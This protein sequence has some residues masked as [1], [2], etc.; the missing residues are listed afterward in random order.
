MSKRDFNKASGKDAAAGRQEKLPLEIA[1]EEAERAAR[2]RQQNQAASAEQRESRSEAAGQANNKT[3]GPTAP[4]SE[5]G[6]ETAGR[7]QTASSPARETAAGISAG[8]A[9]SSRKQDAE[10]KNLSSLPNYETAP[11][12]K[13]AEAPRPQEAAERARTS[14]APAAAAEPAEPAPA[15]PEPQDTNNNYSVSG[16]PP[17]FL[18]STPPQQSKATFLP[19]PVFRE[20]DQTEPINSSNNEHIA[21][22]ARA[23]RASSKAFSRA[24]RATRTGRAARSAGLDM[25]EEY[26]SRGKFRQSLNIVRR[27]HPYIMD[28]P[29]SIT[30]ED[31]MELVRKLRAVPLYQLQDAAVE[32]NAEE[33]KRLFH[34][35]L[36]IDDHQTYRALQ[37]LA[38]QRAS[39]SLYTIGWS[40]LQRYFPQRKIQQTLELV[41]NTLESDP[42][43]SEVRPSYIRK[44]IGDIINLGKSDEGL[45]SDVVR[46]MNQAYN[47][48]PDEGLESFIEDYQ[49]LIETPFGGSVLGDFFR[50]ADLPVLY[51][52]KEILC[53]AL[54]YMHPAMAAEVVS[55]V[56]ASRDSIEEDKKYIYKEVADI[57]LHKE[58][59]HPM[60]LYMSTDL[61]RAYNRWY[62]DDRLDNQTTMYPGKWEFLQTYIE[63][64]E[65]VAMLSNDLMAIRFDNFILIDDRRR[66][67]SCTFYDNET[68]KELLLQGLDEKDLGNPGI[69]ARNVKEAL[70]SGRLNGVVHLSFAQ[71]YLPSSRQFMDRMLGHSNKRRRENVLKNW[72]R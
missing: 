13:T 72:F 34:A 42:S 38:V 26:K 58:A 63:D 57:F 16:P 31:A 23:D 8:T 37:Q 39:W 5:S 65:D 44:A 20:Q 66:G 69:P 18:R 54:P 40:S 25:T 52:K 35:L 50:R 17:S 14:A 36:L 29:L 3:A 70:Q 30:D 71:G 19:R 32:I 15:A 21:G 60:W 62:I 27:Q 9:S 43:R 48:S 49:I 24:P 68:V 7:S 51:R 1:L 53:R 56:I 22:L 55:R 61:K 6:S 10:D 41:Y 33:S 11:A 46:N 64:I 47:V 12:K 59:S 2:L 67:D 4:A 45:V 28:R